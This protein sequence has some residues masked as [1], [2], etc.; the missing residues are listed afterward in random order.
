MYWICSY[1]VVLE[2]IP[3]FL[4]GL[5]AARKQSSDGVKM[6]LELNHAIKRLKSIVEMKFCY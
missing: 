1:L 5:I 4:K 2:N 6:Q 3:F